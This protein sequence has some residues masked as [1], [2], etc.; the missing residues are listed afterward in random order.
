M[1]QNLNKIYIK[2]QIHF[3]LTTIQSLIK[4]LK[5]V[6]L[7]TLAPDGSL[8]SLNNGIPPRILLK[9]LKSNKILELF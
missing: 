6:M 3:F 1:E 5:M 7:T 4:D 8:H 9:S 2:I